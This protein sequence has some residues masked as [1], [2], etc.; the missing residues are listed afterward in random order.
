MDSP[1]LDCV[2]GVRAP[3]NDGDDSVLSKH[4]LGAPLKFA[5]IDYKQYSTIMQISEPATAW[6]IGNG[7]TPS[8]ANVGS[9]PIRTAS[10]WTPIK[11]RRKIENRR[12][13]N[14]YKPRG[15]QPVQVLRHRPHCSLR[16]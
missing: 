14:V 6:S 12:A 16:I 5:S 8:M 3:R 10:K 7:A 15:K 2:V 11:T 13:R 1:I 9:Q 4:A